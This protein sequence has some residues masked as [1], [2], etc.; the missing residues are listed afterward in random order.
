MNYLILLPVVIEADPA[1]FRDAAHKGFQAIADLCSGEAAATIH[2][3]QLD[4][5]PE[6]VMAQRLL[7]CTFTAATTFEL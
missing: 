5:S 1:D 2:M 3:L 4:S 6:A 7:S